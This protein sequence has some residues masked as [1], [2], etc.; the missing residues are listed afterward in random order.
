ML[1]FFSVNYV[2]NSAVQPLGPGE[3]LNLSK[4]MDKSLFSYQKQ[5]DESVPNVKYFISLASTLYQNLCF[6]NF[7]PNVN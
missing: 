6:A 7:P 4:V 1:W 2:I 3:V 5:V